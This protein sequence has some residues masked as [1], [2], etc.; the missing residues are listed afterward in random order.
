LAGPPVA[1]RLTER[2]VS[3]TIG[4]SCGRHGHRR[5]VSRRGNKSE[6]GHVVRRPGMFRAIP[7][8]L[9]LAPS[10]NPNFLAA[11]GV[12]GGGGTRL[13]K[14]WTACCLGVGGI[15]LF[16]PDP[17][18][19][20]DLLHKLDKARLMRLHA[21]CSDRVE[22]SVAPGCSPLYHAGGVGAAGLS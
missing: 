15:G 6:A 20:A 14:R 19:L 9:E 10:L 18:G 8:T 4:K 1:Q 12:S 22:W 7:R 17:S 3:T 11:A 13:A 21:S 16:V 2:A 5:H